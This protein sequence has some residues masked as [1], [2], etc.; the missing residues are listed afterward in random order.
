MA[1][2]NEMTSKERFRRSCIYALVAVTASSA[3]V[4]ILAVLGGQATAQNSGLSITD[5]ASYVLAV[6]LAPGWLMVRGMFE[7]VEAVR[8]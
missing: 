3:A 7:K 4:L 1:D 5:L 6:P 2:D 8:R